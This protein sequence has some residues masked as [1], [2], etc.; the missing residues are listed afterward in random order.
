MAVDKPT[1][2][3]IRSKAVKLLKVLADGDWYTTY[4]GT[5]ALHRGLNGYHT[6]IKK[7]LD[8]MLVLGLVE[9]ESCCSA[10]SRWHITQKGLDYIK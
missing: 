9:W 10:H 6:N 4:Q 8:R 7:R 5:K 1:G 3:L 2:Y